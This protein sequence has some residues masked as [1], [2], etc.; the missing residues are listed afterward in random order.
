MMLGEREGKRKK[1]REGGGGR[2][3]GFFKELQ[4]LLRIVWN[5]N[6][7]ARAFV[8]PRPHDNTQSDISAVV[9]VGAFSGLHSLQTQV[10]PWF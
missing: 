6:G 10:N 5:V 4:S 3:G 2:K 1:G 9:F 8:A 7:L